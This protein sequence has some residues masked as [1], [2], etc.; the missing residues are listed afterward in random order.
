MIERVQQNGAV[1]AYVNVLVPLVSH[2]LQVEPLVFTRAPNLRNF[3]MTS[4]LK[5]SCDFSKT[6]MC[7]FIFTKYTP[8]IEIHYFKK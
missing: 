5:I 3:K 2:Y 8:N 1:E 4:Y 7:F 6:H